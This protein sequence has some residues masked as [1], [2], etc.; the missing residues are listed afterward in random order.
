MG[1]VWSIVFERQKEVPA[2]FS[3]RGRNPAYFKSFTL[4]MEEVSGL[5]K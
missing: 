3:R 1:A 4:R 5:A 2:A